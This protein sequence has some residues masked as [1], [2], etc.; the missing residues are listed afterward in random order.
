MG[1]RGP[2]PKPAK[3]RL[4]VGARPDRVNQHEPTSDLSALAW[5][6]PGDD[7]SFD[8][9]WRHWAPEAQLRYL[10]ERTAGLASVWA[11]DGWLQ[12]TPGEVCDYDHIRTAINTD[13]EDFD[14]HEV[15]YDPWNSTQL[16]NDLLADD[17]PMVRMRQGFV[18]MS[19]PTKELLRILLEGKARSPK[20]RHGGNPLLRWQVDHLAVETD[21]AGNVKP[22]KKTS[23]DKIDGVVALIMGL[24]R[25]I[26]SRRS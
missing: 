25:A 12:L 26:N 9:V 22:S 17:A 24:D 11:R 21:A 16:V 10:D 18:S 13:R 7:G 15:A 1:R 20:L 19:P 6:F 5:V 2:Q 3:L 8:V 23:S 14:V 4:V